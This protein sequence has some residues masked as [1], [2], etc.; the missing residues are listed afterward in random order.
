[1]PPAVMSAA[2]LRV[3][4]PYLV[5]VCMSRCC[6]SPAVG[7]GVVMEAVVLDVAVVAAVMESAVH[8]GV[9]VCG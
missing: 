5:C 6:E 7:V 9:C 4:N 8:V 2:P 1:L 3:W